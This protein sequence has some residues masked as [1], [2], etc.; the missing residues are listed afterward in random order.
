MKYKRPDKEVVTSEEDPLLSF[1]CHKRA[2]SASRD[3]YIYAIDESSD[4]RE[5][6]SGVKVLIN[7]VERLCSKSMVTSSGIQVIEVLC[8]PGDGQ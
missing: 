2:Y 7:G 1:T 5:D 6:L 3:S 4:F 8:G